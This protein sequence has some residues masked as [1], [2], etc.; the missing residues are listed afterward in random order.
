MTKIPNFR[1]WEIKLHPSRVL[2]L[3][4]PAGCGKTT[5]AREIAAAHG[6]FFE[7]KP[8]CLQPPMFCAPAGFSLG[9]STCI[10]DVD[11]VEVGLPDLRWILHLGKILLEHLG[12]WA[13]LVRSP[14][15][16]VC[17]SDQV[18]LP[19]WID[20]QH[21]HVPTIDWAA[22][23]AAEIAHQQAARMTGDEMVV[24]P[25]DHTSAI[26]RSLAEEEDA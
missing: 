17:M 12:E 5:L 23:P 19:A 26:G 4:G 10:F 25:V 18:P 3:R 16:I 15:F 8:E 14:C 21:W 22:Y 6:R 9:L 7:V 13:R 11:S 24:N 2:I 1:P 20:D